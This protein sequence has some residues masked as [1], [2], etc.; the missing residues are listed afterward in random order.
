MEQKRASH[1]TSWKTS[2]PERENIKFKGLETATC[3]GEFVKLQGVWCGWIK[4][5]KGRY[6]TKWSEGPSQE[7]DHFSISS[8][9]PEWLKTLPFLASLNYFSNHLTTSKL[10]LSVPLLSIC[11]YSPTREW[12]F[13][14]ITLDISIFKDLQFS[15]NSQYSYCRLH[16]CDC[17]PLSLSPVGL[18]CIHSS[19]NVPVSLLLLKNTK[20]ASMAPLQ[21]LGPEPRNKLSSDITKSMILFSFQLSAHVLP[22]QR[23]HPP[24]PHP[25]L[26]VSIHFL[27]QHTFHLLFN[28]L[29]SCH[30]IQVSWKLVFVLF[31]VY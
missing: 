24:K 19:P 21:V 1:W 6:K 9:L 17:H 15:K 4:W 2:F 10:L 12:S 7:T 5:S 8:L 11:T 20:H 29:C 3:F 28:F 18:F 16:G 31:I 14:K 23:K 26:S 22:Q 27:L 25:F 13:T 30:R